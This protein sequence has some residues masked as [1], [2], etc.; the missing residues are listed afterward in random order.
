MRILILDEFT[1]NLEPDT[2]EMENGH[3]AYTLKKYLWSLPGGGQ[4]LL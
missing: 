4:G 1:V 3:R 2:I